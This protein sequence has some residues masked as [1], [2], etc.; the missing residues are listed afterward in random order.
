MLP[1]PFPQPD[2]TQGTDLY[3]DPERFRALF[4]PDVPARTAARM[5]TAQRPVSSAAGQETSTA[6]TWKTIP[7]W[8]LIGRQD[9]VINRDAQRFIAKRAHAHTIAINSS[10]ASYISHPGT[11]TKLILRA[12]RKVG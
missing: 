2:G 12:A 4:A 3:I 11:V 1:R 5:A 8:Y 6:P 7:S 9:E 10:H